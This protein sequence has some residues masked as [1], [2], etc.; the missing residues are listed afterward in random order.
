MNFTQECSENLSLRYLIAVRRRL[1]ALR[2]LAHKS[3]EVLRPVAEQLRVRTS[4]PVSQNG[5]ACAGGNQRANFRAHRRR[6]AICG[7]NLDHLPI[8]PNAPVIVLQPPRL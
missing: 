2:G 5:G 7:C 6:H 3:Y 8:A 1:R 4:L